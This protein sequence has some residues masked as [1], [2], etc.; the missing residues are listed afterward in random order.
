MKHKYLVLFLATLLSFFY[1]N[2]LQAQVS[3]S[4]NV[5][6]L[7][8]GSA[9]SFTGNGGTGAVTYNWSFG[10]GASSTL[11]NPVHTFK[12]GGYY[13]VNFQAYNSNGAFLGNSYCYITV[14]GAPDSLYVSSSQVC[15]HDQV[16]V[17]FNTYNS[18]S[19]VTW[20]FGDGYVTT[21]SYSNSQHVYTV[22]GTYLVRAFVKTSCGLDTCYGKVHVVN[23]AQ[24][25]TNPYFSTQADSICPNDAAVFYVDYN[26]PNYVLDYGDGTVITH[27]PNTNNNNTQLT[28]VYPAV[29]TYPAKITYLNSCGNSKI[30]HDTIRVVNNHKVSGYVSIQVNYGQHRDT[31]CLNS[32]VQF[33]P[34]GSGYRSYLWNFGAGVNDT[35]TQTTPSHKFTSLGKPIVTLT[36]TNGCG[37]N[38]VVVDT[39]KIVNTLRFGGLSASVTPSSIC[40]GQAILYDAYPTNGGG[41]DP[42]FS[43]AWSFGDNTTGSGSQGSHTLNV[44]GTYSVKCVGVNGCG[45]KDSLTTA[46]VVATGVTPLK[47]DYRYMSTASNRPACPNDSILFIFA[48]AG[49]GTVH[50]DFGDAHSGTATGTLVFQNTT[51]R[52]IKHAFQATG[53]YTAT[54]TYTNSCGNSFSDTLSVDINAHVSDFGSGN[55]NMIL[56]DNTVYPCQGTPIPFYAIEGSNYIWNFGDGTGDLVT[57]QTLT[58]VYHA[59]QNAGKY[60]VTLRAFNACGNSATDTVIVNIPASLITITTNSVN[61]HCHKSN[62]KAIAVASGGTTPYTYQWSNGKSKFVDDSVAA[63]IYVI[64]VTDAHGCSNFHI[65]TVNDAEAPTISVGSLV[66]VSC[67]G[68]NDG[69]VSIN[70]IGGSSPFTYHWST[71]ATTSSI[72]NQVAG[73]R[74]VTVTDV[75]GC[76]ASKSIHIGESSPV[77]VSII[78]KS[79]S[80]G[81]ADGSATAAVSGTTGPYNY[82]W[83][84]NANTAANTGLSPGS[85]SVTV[86]DNNGCLFNADATVS[87]V[88]GPLV[89]TDSI[90]GKGCGNALTA[91]YTHSVA[92]SSPYTYSWSNGATTSNLTNGSVGNYLLTVTGSNGCKSLVSFNITHDAPLDNPICMVTV[93]SSTNTNLLV[94]NKLVTAQVSHYNIY[95][96]SSQNGLYYMVD[97]VNNTSLSEWTDPVANPQVRSWKYKI[98]VVDNCGDES[99][100]SVEHKTIHLN[101]N[102][103]LGGVYNL[104]WDEYTGFAYST[105]NIFRYTQS[106]GWQQIATV[107]SNVLSYTDATPPVNTY[108]YRVDAVPNFSCTPT[109]RYANGGNGTL[110]SIN[111]TH[112]NIKTVIQSPTGVENELL[113]EHMNLYPNPTDGTFNLVYP[114]SKEGYRLSVYDAI[115]QLVYSAEIPKEQAE[116][117][118]NTKSIN[119]TGATQGIYIVSLDNGK[120]K[121]FRKLMIR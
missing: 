67:Y 92:G 113:G 66:N 89:Y 85:Y 110:A 112:S 90:T 54:V 94:W 29:G 62:G 70:L 41:N 104:I 28:H 105:F 120:T 13:Y 6:T 14:N 100:V 51:Y 87:N 22:N 12:K 80:C 118:T 44:P 65:A 30:M 33:Y 78:V 79:A 21:N 23:N 34:N 46:I 102:Q 15:P 16:G 37:N 76:Q 116:F 119:L 93:D 2:S 63:G 109:T 26:F 18:I 24:I 43:F 5:T 19:S 117:G 77:N 71:G 95:K 17:S 49:N 36:V 9:V 108:S 82:I 35:S 121:V 52:I 20:D 61:A 25:T 72:N 42:S 56:Y 86:V 115:G 97:T 8:R 74:E 88:N 83:S 99:Y 3:C 4:S 10:D 47:A 11:K 107:P 103:G 111:S 69:A 68:G 64:N 39:V 73:P 55:G 106:G 96:E 32:Y 114:S 40:P 98:S 53:H 1:E 84:N 48:P 59:F 91:I 50:W 81:V 27:V 57:H 101:V 7:C 45:S 60:V 58:A 75:N 31:A 38:R